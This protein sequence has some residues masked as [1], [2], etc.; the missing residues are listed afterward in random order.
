MLWSAWWS[1]IRKYKLDILILFLRN[2]SKRW[3][4]ESHNALQLQT[5]IRSLE[6]EYKW[7]EVKKNKITLNVYS[8][9]T[10]CLSVNFRNISRGP[11]RVNGIVILR[12][13]TW[14]GL[15]PRV[16]TAFP[17]SSKHFLMLT[18]DKMSD[19]ELSITLWL[20]SL[21]CVTANKTESRGFQLGKKYFEAVA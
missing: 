21:P 13:D 14:I 19:L 5:G 6:P 16:T 9:D 1:L 8:V 17:M 10:F 4:R 20:N 12:S 15:K 2:W 18:V 3:T 7:S 11:K